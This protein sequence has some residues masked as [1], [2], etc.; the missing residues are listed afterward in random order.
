MK[1]IDNYL[2]ENS[3]KIISETMSSDM[4]PWFFNNYKINTIFD[5]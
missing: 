2:D 1:I 3:F 5:H 4:F